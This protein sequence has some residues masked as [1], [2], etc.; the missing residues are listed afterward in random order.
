M[1]AILSQPQCVNY[2]DVSG[3]CEVTLEGNAIAA[4]IRKEISCGFVVMSQNP[5]LTHW[6]LKTVD[7]W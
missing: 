2:N 5:P 4:L 3:V 7:I 1:A 6:G